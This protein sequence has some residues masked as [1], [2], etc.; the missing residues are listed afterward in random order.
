MA[1]L[2]DE[3]AESGDDD[4][5]DQGAE[6]AQAPYN[7]RSAPLPSALWHCGVCMA[8]MLESSLRLWPHILQQNLL[9]S[10][11]GLQRLLACQPCS[12]SPA[13]L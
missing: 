9:T 4:F 13:A 8:Q 6:F 10:L 12:V 2:E 3:M 11:Q 7:D 1:Y 5:F